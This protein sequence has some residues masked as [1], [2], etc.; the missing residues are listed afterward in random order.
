MEKEYSTK[1][2][3]DIF[4]LKPHSILYYF[5]NHGIGRKGERGRFYF[6]EKEVEII[7]N[8]DGRKTK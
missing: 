7:R 3:A 1:E 4:G 2:V 6:T 5:H 8:T